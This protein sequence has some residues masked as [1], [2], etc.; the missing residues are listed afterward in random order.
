MSDEHSE[1]KPT[2]VVEAER[3]VLRDKSGR[4]RAVLGMGIE[5]SVCLEMMDKNGQR[6][7]CV[8]LIDEKPLVALFD[9]ED[10]PR[11]AMFLTTE[12]VAGIAVC[13]KT[14][15]VIWGVPDSVLKMVRQELAKMKTKGV[16]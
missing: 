15:E 1:N 10:N 2:K 13:D 7:V 6:R 16:H 4:L 12:N 3:F 8:Y 14:G 11:I 5:D 9:E